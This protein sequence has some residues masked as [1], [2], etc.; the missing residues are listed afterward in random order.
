MYVNRRMAALIGL[1]FASGLPLMLTGRA[2]TVWSRDQGLDLTTIGLFSLVTLPYTLKF[3]WAPA[4]DRFVPPMLGRRRGWLLILQ[5]LLVIAITL[6]ALSGP[7]EGPTDNLVPF[8]FFALAV[9]FFSASQDIVA[10]AYR[11]DVL[12]R[13][14]LGPGASVYMTGYRLAMLASG[15]GA[16]YLASWMAWS[17][18]YILAA[19]SMSIGI[20]ATLLAPEPAEDVRAPR[21]FAAAVVEPAREFI[22]RNRRRAWIVLVFVVAFKLPDYM[23]ARMTDPLLL[24][25][26]F[27]K[28]DIAFWALGVGI[29]VTIPGV[30]V[31]GP[32][33]TRL[34][35]VR[36][37]VVFGV[38]QALSN[39]G[40]MLLAFSGA[41]YWLMVLVIGIEY[42]CMGLV[43]AGFVAFL[44]SQCDK[45]YSATQYALLSSLM[46]LSNALAGAPTGWL[47]EVTSYPVFFLI[48]ILAAI[49]GL[50][51]LPWLREK[52]AG[53]EPAAKW[54]MRRKAQRRRARKGSATASPRSAKAPGVGMA[55]T[56][57]TR[58]L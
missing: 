19:A 30:L 53:A 6:M 51:M 37:L 47:V 49:P 15:A 38:A 27:T 36:A 12:A 18:V 48:T 1:G 7:G 22:R 42:F 20:A 32:I 11:T 13:E 4:M 29:A 41:V 44:M 14:E 5:M 58:S 31:G 45:R 8:V 34:G 2:M 3:L 23:A 39:A 57:I 24:D 52:T 25:L 55:R 17:V 46:G 21:T 40:Y 28:G 56:S 16:V 33:V 35:L 43:V 9:A 26:G 10:D 50:L 54:R